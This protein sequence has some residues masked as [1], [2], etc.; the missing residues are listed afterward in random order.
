MYFFLTNLSFVDVSFSSTVVLRMLRDL[1]IT[2]KTILFAECVT[3]MYI[4]ASVGGAE[5]INLAVL[6]YDRYIAICYPLQYVIIIN[7]A[8]CIKITAATWICAFLLTISHVALTMNVKFCGRNVINHF[9]CEVPEILALGCGNVMAAEFGIFIIAVIMLIVP[10]SF[11]LGTYIKI[12]GAI[13][14]IS[15]SAGRKKT[16]STCSSHIMV[17][18]MFYGSVAAA[19]MKPQSKALPNIDKIF[20]IFY[21]V[22]T[23]MLNPLI[24][25]LR[26]KKVKSA[27]K[28]LQTRAQWG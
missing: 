20:A 4:A 24:Y 8:A 13:L 26:N 16:F 18:T 23:P 28:K 19:Y 27:L 15:S 6:A 1:L 11:I 7:K 14:K 3:Q 10:L 5:C 25:T 2:K 9:F 17:V 12:I 22:V 21:T